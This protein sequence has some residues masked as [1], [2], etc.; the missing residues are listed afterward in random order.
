M[1]EPVP[2]SL[3]LIAWHGRDVTES[4]ATDGWRDGGLEAEEEEEENKCIVLGAENGVLWRGQI[5]YVG[6]QGAEKDRGR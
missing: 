3:S 1:A 5:A 6:E 4:G 2:A